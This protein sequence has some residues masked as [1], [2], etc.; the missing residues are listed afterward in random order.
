VSRHDYPL[1][2]LSAA[3]PERTDLHLQLVAMPP[4]K[5]L[6]RPLAPIYKLSV[7]CAPLAQGGRKRSVRSS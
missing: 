4:G 5:V 3:E 2:A 6:S 1:A 7:I